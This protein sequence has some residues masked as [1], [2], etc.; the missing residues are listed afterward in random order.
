MLYGYG[1]TGYEAAGS[2]HPARWYKYT[3]TPQTFSMTVNIPSAILPYVQTNVT[4]IVQ[5]Y[6]Q[7]T[8]VKLNSSGT[9]YEYDYYYHLS[10]FP[11]QKTRSSGGIVTVNYNDISGILTK[12]ND[13][14]TNEGFYEWGWYGGKFVSMRMEA[15]LG[16]PL[17]LKLGDH[18]NFSNLPWA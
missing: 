2:S 7:A 1:N 18:T 4:A 15:I 10:S 12:L 5:I 6:S 14:F 13:Y 3:Y 9:D 17:V 8:T 16:V 11:L